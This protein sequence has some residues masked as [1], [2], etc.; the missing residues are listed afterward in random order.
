MIDTGA[1]GILAANAMEQLAERYE[2]TATVR[3]IGLVIEVL[4]EE[5]RSTFHVICT[6]ERGWVKEALLDEG[7]AV[8]HDAEAEARAPEEDD[9]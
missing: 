5:R 4:D 7:I 9:E 6:D 3:E 1:V 2:S 8:I